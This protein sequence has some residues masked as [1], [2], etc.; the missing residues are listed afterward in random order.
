[1]SQ[2]MSQLTEL[3][4][5]RRMATVAFIVNG[6]YDSAMGYR[7]RDL[8][9]HLGHYDIRI[10]YRSAGKIISILKLLV[11]LTR[12]R[13][14]VIYVFDVSYSGVLAAG[15]YRIVFGNS[16]ITETGDAIV[17]LAQS[18]GNRGRLGLWL[19]GLLEKMAFATADRIVVRGSFHKQLLSPRGIEAE[20][21]QDGVDTS[22]FT[23]AEVTD[24]R[25]QY[26]L[27][28]ALTLGLVGSSIWSKKLQMCYGWELV[29]TLKLLKGK[30]VHGIMI[31]NGSGIPHLKGRCREYGIENMITFLDHVPY[32]QL[33]R[34]LNL[35]DVCLST[36]TNDVVG[37][38]RT[39]GKLPLYLAAARYIL[40][41][42]VG[43]AARVLDPEMLVPYEGVK[44]EQY[45][46]KLA[47]RIE[48]ILEH[49]ELLNRADANVALAEKHFDYSL[50]AKR[51]GN[52]IE[53]ARHT[54]RRGHGG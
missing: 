2:P 26:G 50:L 10:A 7:A 49:P 35:I 47:T 23:P 46:Q 16:L 38:V 12:V 45:P 18:T 44:D 52:V 51:V 41:S 4:I 32:D 29:E 37:K 3:A 14:A 34:Y 43:E 54:A 11:F 13:P 20:V 25:F 5:P 42:D 15:V 28:G 9:A 40:A 8:A 24:L 19:T 22:R 36:Q 33:P 53:A 30:H 1:M 6:S 17:E 27:H 39:T 21:I 31:G 48:T